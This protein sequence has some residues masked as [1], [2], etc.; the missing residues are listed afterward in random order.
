MKHFI[1]ENQMLKIASRLLKQRKF[2]IIF[3]NHISYQL[4]IGIIARDL[5]QNSCGVVTHTD[6]AG[7]EEF[8]K[9]ER[10]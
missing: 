8:G 1:K 4:A 9:P 6:G 3:P 5:Y 10:L 7:Y 2:T